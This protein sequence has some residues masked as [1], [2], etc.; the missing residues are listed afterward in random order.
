[1]K[2]HASFVLAFT[3]AITSSV[4]S[5]PGKPA[6]AGL[7]TILTKLFGDNNAFTADVV[8]TETV[9]DQSTTMP[10]KIARNAGELRTEINPGDAKSP[11]MKPENIAHLKTMGLGTTVQI[12]RA[13][14]KLSYFLYPNLSAYVATPL[15]NADAK[16]ASDFKVNITE[17]GKETVGGHPCVKNKVVV[18]D[19]EGATYESTVWNATDL[20]KFPIK[21]EIPKQDQTITLALSN[22]KTGKPDAALF[23]LPA[24]YKKYDNKQAI[25]FEQMKK[26]MGSMVP[27][28]GQAP[29][30]NHP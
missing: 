7:S 14:K 6:T 1:M 20:K 10:G 5:Q 28:T 2:K 3:L 24:N 26:Q 30:T 12:F 9:R 13:D 23:E 15:Q 21:I 11:R 22:I 19:H 8:M 4:Y 27:P 25:V 17:L 29:P 18:T 16:P